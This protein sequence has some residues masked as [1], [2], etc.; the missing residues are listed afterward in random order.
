[1]TR[2]KGKGRKKSVDD[3]LREVWRK[4]VA[5]RNTKH[6][7][8]VVPVGLPRR[9]PERRAKNMQIR[10]STCMLPPI[11]SFEEAIGRLKN[12]KTGRDVSGEY[13][14]M[15]PVEYHHN[16][17]CWCEGGHKSMRFFRSLRYKCYTES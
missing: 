9:E 11:L 16:W 17:A 14:P 15:H 5:R 6:V 4:S 7:D 1:M 12:V 10:R 2:S 3:K 8:K 13:G